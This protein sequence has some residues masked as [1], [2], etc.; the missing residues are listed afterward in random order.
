MKTINPD[1]PVTCSKTI[2][3]DADPGRVWAVLTNIDRWPNWQT[4][5]RNSKLRG[6]LTPGTLFDWKSGG[7]AIHSTL[8]TV[9]P[10]HSFGWT[11]KSF[12][13][14]AIHNWTLSA[15]G[16]QTQ[17]AVEESMEGI[18]VRIFRKPFLKNLEKGLENWLDLL[19]TECEGEI[20]PA[21]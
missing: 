2:H 9:D 14:F 11:G 10:F 12:G 17:V 19:K 3:I 5:I 8:H 1:A 20:V 15:V 18:L 16:G 6:E 13:I 21:K 7:V 4:D